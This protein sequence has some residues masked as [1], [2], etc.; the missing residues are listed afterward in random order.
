MGVPGVI[1]AKALTAGNTVQ[2]ISMEASN[3]YKILSSF[4][5]LK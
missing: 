3:K 5:P 1:Y 2:K 4:L